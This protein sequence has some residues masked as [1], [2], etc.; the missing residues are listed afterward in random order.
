MAPPSSPEP[1][2]ASAWRSRACSV[3]RATPSRSPGAVPTSSRRPP[4]LGDA[5]PGGARVIV[6]VDRLREAGGGQQALEA[7][8]QERPEIVFLRYAMRLAGAR[9]RRAVGG[10]RRAQVDLGGQRRDE[11]V[12]EH[13]QL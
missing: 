1:R 11:L 6:V 13:A 2:V 4:R 12:L 5:H 3:R 8:I 7:A 9:G 10:D